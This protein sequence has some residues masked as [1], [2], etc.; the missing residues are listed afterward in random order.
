MKKRNK[1]V[2]KDLKIPFLKIFFIH[3]FFNSKIKNKKVFT[4]NKKIFKSKN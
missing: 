1:K 2:Y 3:Q 4:K